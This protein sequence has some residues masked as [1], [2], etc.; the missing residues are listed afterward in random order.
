MTFF[1]LGVEEE[2]EEVGKSTLVQ[3]A[4]FP[5][6]SHNN[7]HS[8]PSLN[9]FLNLRGSVLSVRMRPVPSVR[10][11]NAFPPQLSA[12]EETGG[13]SR[14]WYL[15]EAR[16]QRKYGT[17][18]QAER[19]AHGTGRRGRGGWGGGGQKGPVG[20][21]SLESCVHG[22]GQI[23]A[24]PWLS[25]RIRRRRG[26]KPPPVVCSTSIHMGKEEHLPSNH[27]PN[28]RAAEDDADDADDRVG[29]GAADG[30]EDED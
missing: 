15:G 25:G 27:H 13:R 10:R 20:R 1:A 26:C 4:A 8:V 2:K 22:G 9:P 21:R 12:R 14:G 3:G 16:R 24:T 6:S 23:A 30:G 7:T 28:D 17:R 29:T 5:A 19:R 18:T 11:R